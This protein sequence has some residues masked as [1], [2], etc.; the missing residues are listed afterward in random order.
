LGQTQVISISNPFLRLKAFA[1]AREHV[2]TADAVTGWGLLFIDS[3]TCVIETAKGEN[4]STMRRWTDSIKGSTFG[5]RHYFYPVRSKATGAEAFKTLTTHLY[6]EDPR[7]PSLGEK[8]A[9]RF[10]I[11]QV[12]VRLDKDTLESI[13]NYKNQILEG[14]KTLEKTMSGGATVFGSGSSEPKYE[15][16]VYDVSRYISAGGLPIVTGGAHG[17]MKV[18]NAAATDAGGVSIGIPMTG[19]KRLASEKFV[20]SEVQT[21]TIST[22]DYSARIPLLLHMNKYVV[23]M[24]GGQGTMQEV[25]TAFFK[26]AMETHQDQK[27]IFVAKDFYGPL[28]NLLQSSSLP[29]SMKSRLYLV[30]SPEQVWPIIGVTN[31]PKIEPRKILGDR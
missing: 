5:L 27:I 29:E 26:A 16:L 8:T 13:L 15:N 11:K 21:L 12:T 17:F 4:D 1:A 31:P 25:G 9:I 20:A 19:R 23:V 24:P 10:D 7:P 22:T 3:M 2:M 6:R 14:S 30:D 18:A 28:F